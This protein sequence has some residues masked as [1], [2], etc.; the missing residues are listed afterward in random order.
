MTDC[1]LSGTYRVMGAN[2]ISMIFKKGQA[3]EGLRMLKFSSSKKIA[4]VSSPR[5]VKSVMRLKSEDTVK[6]R[7]NDN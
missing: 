1:D 2:L 5:N 7:S 3:V 4:F 6:F